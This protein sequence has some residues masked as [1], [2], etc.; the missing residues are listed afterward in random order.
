MSELTESFWV[1]TEVVLA[2]QQQSIDRYGGMHGLRDEGLLDSALMR[3]QNVAA[4]NQGSSLFELAACYAFALAKNHP[5]I[6]GNKRIAFITCAVFLEYN[7]YRVTASQ[8]EAYAM[9]MAIAD[10]TMHEEITAA[11][12]KD[13][14]EKINTP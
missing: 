6:D 5:F 8:E 4:Y 10:G 13:N 3:P 1:P 11:W 14:V 12:L 7:G 2:L 9:I